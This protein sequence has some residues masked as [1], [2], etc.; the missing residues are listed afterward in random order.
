MQKLY[1]YVDETGQDTKGKFFLVSIVIAER[2]IKETVE[3]QLL[4]IERKTR[5]QTAKW[6]AAPYQR[7]IDYLNAILEMKLL[8]NSIFYSVYKTTKEYVPLTTYTIAKAIGTKS[9]ESYQA[10]ITIDGLNKKQRQQVMRGLRQLRVKYKKVRG[11]RDQSDP[12]IRLADTLAGFLR[13]FEEKQSYTKLIF[14]KF[15]NKQFLTK[16]E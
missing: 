15:L 3:K 4:E 7:R 8:K 16:L 1:C 13:D 12:L 9:G 6:Q 5:K 11:A 10:I 2:T 14:N